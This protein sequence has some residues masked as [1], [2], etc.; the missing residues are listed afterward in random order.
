MPIACRCFPREQIATIPLPD[1]KS[2]LV[3][4]TLIAK[5]GGP[6][7]QGQMLLDHNVEAGELL[8]LVVGVHNGLLN[9]SVQFSVAPS[10]HVPQPTEMARR[11]GM[12]HEH[13]H[14]RWR[15]RRATGAAEEP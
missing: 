4:V 3:T 11:A 5:D 12:G 14:G 2:I 9:Q 10:G 7:R 6:E 8:V 15:V 1:S 13:L